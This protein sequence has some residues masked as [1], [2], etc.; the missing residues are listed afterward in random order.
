M[1]K[2]NSPFLVLLLI[3]TL[4]AVPAFSQS[5]ID[6]A[7]E[8]HKQLR[9]EFR[10]AEQAAAKMEAD[11]DA[12]T[13]ELDKLTRERQNLEADVIHYKGQVTYAQGQLEAAQKKCSPS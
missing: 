11:N 2:P 5:S 12:G 1:T 3:L 10:K 13:R 6:S 4:Q 9:E 7:T 8:Q